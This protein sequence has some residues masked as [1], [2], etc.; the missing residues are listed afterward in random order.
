MHARFTGQTVLVT[1]GGSSPI[2]QTAALAFAR[3]G[4]RVVVAGRTPEPL[5]HTTELVRAEGGEA[6]AVTADVTKGEDVARL[7][8]E[9]VT[10]YGGLDI[11][12]NNAGILATPGTLA[13]LDEEALSTAWVNPT[14][15][16]LAMKHQVAHMRAHGGG[17]IINMASTIGAHM[18]IPGMGA[19]AAGKAA[20]SALTRTAAQEYIDEG[21]RINSVSPGPVDTWMSRMPGENDADRDERMRDALPIGRVASTEEIAAAVLWLASPESGFA[22]GLDLVLDGGATA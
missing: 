20:V 22:V 9:T 1:G 2:G 7:V 10:R 17:T 12:F 15:T 3:E 11:A 14:G 13:E 16:W 18:T 19:Y 6:T 8:A 21:V 5:A 4:A